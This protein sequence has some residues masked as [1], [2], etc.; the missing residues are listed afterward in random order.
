MI[1]NQKEPIAAPCDITDQR[2]DTRHFHRNSRSI[3]IAQNVAYPYA[4]ICLE[5][6]LN[7]T[8][9][10]FDA[11]PAWLNSA[12]MGQRAND[13]DCAVSTHAQISHIV[14]EEH[15]CNALRIARLTQE[16]AHNN[17]G[18]ARLARQSGAKAIV[19]SAQ[20]MESLYKS[21]FAQVRPAL[22]D[23]TRRLSFCV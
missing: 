17:I 4:A 13:T 16:R 5:F 8:N 10:R 2:A 7:F 14:K 9:R 1:A 19:L 15:A 6:G 3:P 18:A 11:V 12:Q 20:N 21:A 23:D 22:D